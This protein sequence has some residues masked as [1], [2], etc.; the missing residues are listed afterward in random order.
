[1]EQSVIAVYL[2][3]CNSVLIKIQAQFKEYTIEEKF[4]YN[5]IAR[6]KNSYFFSKMAIQRCSD[7]LTA[8]TEKVFFGLK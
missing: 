5:I 7:I 2:N 6:K 1:M 3:D 4:D 8:I